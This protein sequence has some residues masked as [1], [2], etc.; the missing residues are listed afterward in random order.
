MKT[1]V[2]L[3]S[4]ALASVVAADELEIDKGLRNLKN[5]QSAA[6]I[7]EYHRAMG[8]TSQLDTRLADPWGTLY[9]IDG[10]R[11]RII[12][13]GSDRTFDEASWDRY[14]Q[15]V[16]L[17]GDVVFQDGKMFRSNRN[18]LYAHVTPGKASEELD[19]L[20]RAEAQY[21]TTLP[22]EVRQGTALETSAIV[23]QSLGGLAAKYYASHG[24]FEKIAALEDPATPMVAEG[25]GNP[26]VLRDGWG[27]PL[28]V[29]LKGD[30][31]R[32]VSAGSDRHFDP[33]TWSRA[34]SADAS[35]DVIFEDGVFV[36]SVDAKALVKEAPVFAAVAQPPDPAPPNFA[37]MLRPGGDVKAPVAV[38]RVEPVYPEIYRELRV[39][40]IVILECG[41]SAS[42]TVDSVRVLKSLAPDFDM[43]AADAVRRW[44]FK[45]GTRDGAAVPV[46]F[47]LTINFKLK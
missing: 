8:T 40:G 34:A 17:E 9:R 12:G 39:G 35:E 1:A 27:T 38:E 3:L 30:H 14:E 20:R 47:N 5:I 44:K 11:G 26:R 19:A 22:P 24:N 41:I 2:A 42:G 43:A 37:E 23:M 45:P 46:L 10:E 25:K 31:Y 15:V 4:L 18:W 13:A 21:M 6:A 29:I 33:D 32:I 16:G 36:R 7:I 28:R